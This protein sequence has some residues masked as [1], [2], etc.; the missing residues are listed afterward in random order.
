MIEM[1]GERRR[2]R[3]GKSIGLPGILVYNGRR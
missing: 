3:D 1:E 2:N